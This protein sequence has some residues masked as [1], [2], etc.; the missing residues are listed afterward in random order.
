M[1]TIGWFEILI[2]VVVAIIIVGP[3]DF[4][5]MLKKVGS[6]IG[7]VKRY[8]SNVQNEVSSITEVEIEKNSNENNNINKKKESDEQK[9]S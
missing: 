2:I 9:S 7:S 6:W 1:P 3:K 4:P 8:V 5:L